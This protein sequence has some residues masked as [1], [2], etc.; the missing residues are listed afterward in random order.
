[1]FQ[2]LDVLDFETKVFSV[3]ILILKPFV[4]VPGRTTVSQW[5]AD[6]AVGVHTYFL[7]MWLI[8]SIPQMS[9]KPSIH[10]RMAS[11]IKAG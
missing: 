10:I 4:K 7:R 8:F 11:Q 6:D 3:D 2:I 1:M 9:R 5:I